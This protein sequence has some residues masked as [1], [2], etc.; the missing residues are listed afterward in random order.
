VGRGGT[1]KGPFPYVYVYYGN[2]FQWCL[3]H[4]RLWENGYSVFHST[5]LRILS[6]WHAPVLKMDIRVKCDVEY[7]GNNRFSIIASAQNADFGP[8]L[9]QI[10]TDRRIWSGSSLL[11]NFLIDEFII[12]TYLLLYNMPLYFQIHIVIQG[13]DN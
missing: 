5:Y 9:S 8:Y 3:Q 6:D 13:S 12:L 10:D 1:L 4:M 7:D 2:N 11:Q